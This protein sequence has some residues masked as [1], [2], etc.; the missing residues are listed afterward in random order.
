MKQKS[1][2]DKAP[3][4]QMLK[5]IRR[6]TRRQYSAE[7][8]I[9]IV[10]GRVGKPDPASDRG[11]LHEAEETRR[12][13]VVPGCLATSVLDPVEEAYDAVAHRVGGLVD[14]PLDLPV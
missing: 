3:A 8:K 11:E 2:P 6:Q 1:G 7:K 12:E 14:G 13:L 5:D 4:E 9:R 10:L